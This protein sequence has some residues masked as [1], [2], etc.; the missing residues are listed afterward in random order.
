VRACV[1]VAAS[2]DM[3]VMMMLQTNQL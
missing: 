1:C 3:F 2:L